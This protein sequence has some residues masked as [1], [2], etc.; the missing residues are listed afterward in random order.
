MEICRRSPARRAGP[1]RQRLVGVLAA[2]ALA[3][4]A[5]LSSQGPARA[6][7][8][9]DLVRFLLGAAAI[10]VIVRAIDDSHRPQF[11]GEVLPESCLETVR[12]QGRQI[13]VYN[14]NCLRRA[15]YRNLPDRCEVSYRTAA[16]RRSGYEARCMY[17]SGYRPE[18]GAPPV[19]GRPQPQRPVL[20][21]RCEL[22]YR[23]GGDRAVGYDTLCLRSARITDLPRRCE[24]S[25]RGGD[26]LHDGECLWALGY[27]RGRR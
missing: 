17:R 15:G 5:T 9:D 7:D 16:G 22:N 23:V 11:L 14:R 18:R 2:A 21:A 8:T 27:R 6:Q 19:V 12:L 3:I 10:A 4:A 26:I 20:P 13:D 24:R 1:I 25:I